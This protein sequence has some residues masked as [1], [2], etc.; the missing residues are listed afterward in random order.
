V[1]LMAWLFAFFTAF[2]LLDATLPSLISKMA[3]AGAKGTAMGIYSTS[4]F[5]GA[6]LGGVL[7]G[8]LS[9]QYGLTAVFIGAAVF[10]FVWF[11]LML[12]MTPPRHLSSEVVALGPEQQGDTLDSLME[13][14]A[15]VAGVEDVMVVPEERTV[16][17]KVDRT[18]LDREALARLTENQEGHAA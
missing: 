11:L 18:M 15:A 14:F 16:Y 2:N 5:L 3:P 7:G 1:A 9:Q 6:F 8:W 17:L 10:G 13:R 12:G 4:Q